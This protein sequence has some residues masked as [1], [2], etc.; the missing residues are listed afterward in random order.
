MDKKMF[1]G[2]DLGGTGVK[3]GI[4]DVSGNCRGFARRGYQPSGTSKGHAEIDIEVIEQ[5]AAESAKEAVQAAGEL[6]RSL[7]VSSQGQTFV[8]LDKNARPLHPAIL[9]YDRRG[10]SQA[11]SLNERITA[12]CESAGGR[13]PVS[14]IATVSKILWLRE[15]YPE[16][17]GKAERYLLL[18]DYISYRLTGKAVSDPNTAG[19]TG[20]SQGLDTTYDPPAL[21]AAGIKAGQLA[22]IR[23]AGTPVG[24][25][26]PQKADDWGLSEQTVLVTGT[27]DQYAGALGAGNC[28]PGIA[29]VSTG[30]CMALV[31]LT[32]Q[33][34]ENL[35]CG[36]LSGAF[37]LPPFYFLLAFCKTAGLVLDWFRRELAPSMSLEQLESMAADVPPGCRGL[38]C[39][40]HF[41]GTVS[42]EPDPEVKGAFHGLTLQHGRAEMYRAILES[43]GFALRENIEALRAHGYPIEVIRSIG[44]GAQ[45]RLWLNIQADI[46]GVPVEEPVVKEAAILGAAM[47]AASGCGYFDSLLDCSRNLYQCQEVFLP[48]PAISNIYVPAYQRYRCHF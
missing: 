6:P 25:I 21:S 42:P 10:A 33:K 1:M 43:L 8:S 45:S 17:M 34:P 46:T 16:K 11:D 44:G 32:E 15:H 30:T 38:T 2:L 40:P 28:Q 31:T 29:S 12:Q 7:A 41:D 26:L 48:D 47:L 24:R 22:E 19:S 36:L 3:A 4:F 9:W 37:P 18:P 13:P 20:L 14:D 35:P 23:T 39:V 27:N 5:A